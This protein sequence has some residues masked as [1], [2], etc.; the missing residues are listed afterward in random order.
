[1]AKNS[2][3][4]AVSESLNTTSSV[5]ETVAANDTAN[6]NQILLRAVVVEVLYDLSVFPDEDIF[7]SSVRDQTAGK[8]N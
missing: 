7:K 1:M 2:G 4:D 3:K 6:P 8:L 5:A